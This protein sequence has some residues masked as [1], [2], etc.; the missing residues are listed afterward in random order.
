MPDLN[1]PIRTGDHV[2]HAPTGERWTVAY[3]DYATGYLSWC[4]WPEGRAR[5]EDCQVVQASGETESWALVEEIAATLGSDHRAR[6]CRRLLR[7]RKQGPD[8]GDDGAGDG[9]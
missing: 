9:G 3:A 7:E 6:Y 2:Y 5:I 8:G 4:G 1:R